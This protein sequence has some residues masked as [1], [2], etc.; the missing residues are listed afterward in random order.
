MDRQ[1]MDRNDETTEDVFLHHHSAPAPQP[2][3]P[4]DFG[5]DIDAWDARFPDR[6]VD[7]A[8]TDAAAAMAAAG[9]CSAAVL[10]IG[11]AM[12]AQE[13]PEPPSDAALAAA[14][15][16]A[17]VC[18][19]RSGIWGCWSTG[20]LGCCLPGAEPADLAS[21]M[22]AL[23]DDLRKEIPGAVVLCGVAGH[24]LLSYTAGELV[25]NAAK[26]LAHAAF[27][28]DGAVIT[29]DAT[30]LNISGDRAFAAD[31]V[32]A[33]MA[34]YHNALALDAVNVN[35]L[36]SLGACYGQ[37]GAYEK[38]LAYFDAAVAADPAEYMAIYNIGLT[39]LLMGDRNGARKQFAEAADMAPE[40]FEVAFQLGRLL[41]E[42]GRHAE[43]LVHLERAATLHPGSGTTQKLLGQCH[44]ALDH[45]A[46]AIAAYKKA[47]TQNPNDPETLSA[48]GC[49]FDKQGENPEITII[50]CQQSVDLAP[51]NGRYHLRLG[52]LYL[53]QGMLA[54]AL[55]AF[56][57]ADRCGTDASAQLEAVLDLMDQPPSEMPGDS[58]RPN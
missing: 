46:P 31:D 25:D 37:L 26:A 43:A 48:L 39:K 20:H 8:L 49:L 9:Q 13:H 55:E 1:P 35:V 29:L 5:A 21:L 53:K 32:T 12:D 57:S 51:E 33:A 14:G 58:Q 24:P 2:A 27:F 7:A 17:G 23:V 3:E 22:A 19:E 28:E 47:V 6:L 18:A 16:I 10:R 30:T 11:A 40:V 38:G 36:N 52:Q 56:K 45:L 15:L 4:L 50:F 41:H 44:E 34:E 42:D 54:E